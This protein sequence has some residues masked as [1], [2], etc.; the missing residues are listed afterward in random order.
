MSVRTSILCL[1]LLTV[2][3]CAALPEELPAA[4]TVFGFG[5][6]VPYALPVDWQA[7]YS[8]ISSEVLLTP[9]LTLFL[10]VG[11]YPVLFPILY[12]GGT[13][14]LVRGWI[15]PTVLFAGGG[16]SVQYRRV[17][18]AWA[19]KPHL[20]LRAGF[21]TWFLDSVAFSVH[22]RTLEPLP[23]EWV[24]SPEIALGLNVALGR[25]RPESPRYDG[26]YLWV[27]LGLGAA[28]LIAFLPRK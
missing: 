16:L 2:V 6:S 4:R 9:N 12:E 5:V 24:F 26:D 28:A 21:Q 8:F 13:S 10:D 25:A 14:L 20:N 15:G 17:G 18:H 7:S 11:T 27:L 22:Y 3:A 23:I 19:W 1:V